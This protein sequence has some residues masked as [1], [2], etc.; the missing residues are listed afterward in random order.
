MIFS[1]SGTLMLT[2]P[3]IF[4]VKLLQ[5]NT[6]R[7]SPKAQQGQDTEHKKKE[8]A[9]KQETILKESIFTCESTSRVKLAF[10]SPSSIL[11]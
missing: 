11:L 10:R 5:S 2:E 8:K 7:V 1:V 9:A 4:A 3:I 6:F